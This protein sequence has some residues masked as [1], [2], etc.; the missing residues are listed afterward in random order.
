M[1]S[2]QRTLIRLLSFT[3]ACL[4]VVWAG[5]ASAEEAYDSATE[6]VEQAQV[7]TVQISAFDDG[8]DDPFDIP[9]VVSRYLLP[10]GALLEVRPEPRLPAFASVVPPPHVPPPRRA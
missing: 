6:L 7:Q 2:L 3:L 9:A 8:V 4:V 5:A 1:Q 10:A